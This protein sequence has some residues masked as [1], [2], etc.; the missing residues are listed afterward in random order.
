MKEDI[1]R[2]IQMSHLEQEL[3]DVYREMSRLTGVLNSTKT[4]NRWKQDAKDKMLT[5]TKQKLELESQ[6]TERM[7]L[8]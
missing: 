4:P 2:A 6:I 8:E 5:L 3:N 1:K 7:L